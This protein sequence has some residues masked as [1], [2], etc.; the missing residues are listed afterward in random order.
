MASPHKH[1]LC[2]LLLVVILFIH[3]SSCHAYRLRPT[4]GGPPPPPP[5]ALDLVMS[6]E[7]VTGFVSR[8]REFDFLPR[9]MPIPPSGPSKRHNSA[10]ERRP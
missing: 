2:S 4:R 6:Q 7:P 3:G 1:L 8:G 9:G 10:P 5:A